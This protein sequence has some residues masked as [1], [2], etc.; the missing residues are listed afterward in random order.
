[1]AVNKRDLSTLTGETGWP[2]VNYAQE[3]RNFQ[4]SHNQRSGALSIPRFKFTWLVEF[5]INPR[6][7]ENPVTN[8]R[9]FLCNGKLY[10]HLLTLDHPSPTIRTEKLRSYNKWINVPVQVEFPSA[11]M[12]FHDDSTSVVQ[13][14]WK[15]NLNFY[16]HLAQVGDS[17]SGEGVNSNLS[18]TQE[19]NSYGF[20]HILTGEEQRAKM[21]ERPSL[22]MKLK[23]NDMRHFFEY[24]A[25]Y[26][27]GTEPD[28]IN[29]YWYHKPMITGWQHDNL[30]KEDRTGNVRVSASFD[31][32]SYYFTI[33]QNR[34]RLADYIQTILG[35]TPDNIT[36]APRKDG[37]GRDGRQQPIGQRVEN[38]SGS[39]TLSTF[40]GEDELALQQAMAGGSG[41]QGTNASVAG[42]NPAEQLNSVV[43]LNS[44]AQE[45]L[46]TLN[47]GGIDTVNQSLGEA[48]AQAFPL[49]EVPGTGLIAGPLEAVTP[50][51]PLAPSELRPQI[52]LDLGSKQNDLD[53]VRR[54]KAQ[55]LTASESRP[56]TTPE[57][58]RLGGLAFREDDLEAAINRQQTA[59]AARF[60]DS[61]AEASALQNTV[62]KMGTTPAVN[63][64]TVGNTKE[65]LIITIRGDAAD[66][67]QE[68]VDNL[69]NQL[70]VNRQQQST[71]RARGAAQDVEPFRRLR[72]EQAQLEAARTAEE[73]NVA[74]LLAQRPSG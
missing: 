71:L 36:S 56:L 15:E 41:F 20:T 49:G 13:A 55:L 23:P 11:T 48:T 6:V 28:S 43:G 19:T 30:D 31:Y 40:S 50:Q 22:G 58:E 72:E 60:T 54:E 47:A 57:K 53:Q 16:T 44:P 3:E 52:P 9:E 73:Q 33:G 5:A 21:E 67:A 39:T 18:S 24:I 42:F 74:D 65:P 29:V 8:L 62:N 66:A 26:D 14:L 25:I 68:R 45:L 37:I 10:T 1:M 63:S 35:A 32:E 70:A 4:T 27:L 59:Q 61:P 69:N 38:G 17:I 34:G 46:D 12:T 51:E 2:V 7:W 64:G